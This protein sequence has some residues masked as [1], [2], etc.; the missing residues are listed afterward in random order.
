MPDSQFCKNPRQSQVWQ[1]HKT[2]FGGGGATHRK[3]I[4][5]DV[6]TPQILCLLM[7]WRH[8]TTLKDKATNLCHMDK[9]QQS[10]DN[11]RFIM[12]MYSLIIENLK[13]LYPYLLNIT[14]K[15]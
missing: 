7:G 13:Y 8:S 5:W 1:K 4:Y 9:C 6:G 14:D 11:L 10:K 12:I 2:T 3:N 15:I